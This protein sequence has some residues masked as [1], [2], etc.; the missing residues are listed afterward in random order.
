MKKILI[1]AIGATVVMAMGVPALAQRAGGR[2][3]A[4]PGSGH[5]KGKGSKHHGSGHKHK[6]F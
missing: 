4:S 1:A 2:T 5:H 3:M 6:T